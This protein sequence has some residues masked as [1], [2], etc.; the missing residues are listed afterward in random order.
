MVDELTIGLAFA[1]FLLFCAFM[2]YIGVQARRDRRDLITLVR[3]LASFASTKVLK[4]SCDL[5]ETHVRDH[6]LSLAE[7]R[8]MH[9][10]LE[11][12]LKS[13]LQR[14][15]RLQ[16][17]ESQESEEGELQKLIGEVTPENNGEVSH[18]HEVIRKLGW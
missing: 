4:E 7:L 9:E 13:H 1:A 3:E 18:G 5:L 8:G 17:E 16:R 6:A 10:S 15:Y 2:T 11:Q 12:T 14:F